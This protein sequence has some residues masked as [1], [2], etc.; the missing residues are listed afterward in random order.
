MGNSSLPFERTFVCGAT[1][2]VRSP[3]SPELHKGA[4]FSN[5][6]SRDSQIGGR[7][8][9][10]KEREW[11]RQS[12]AGFAAS[13]PPALRERNPPSNMQKWEWAES[14]LLSRGVQQGA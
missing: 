14:C 4:C 12:H 13:I 1:G 8:E 11:S 3:P 7:K 10:Y 6:I 5:L 9:M 2:E